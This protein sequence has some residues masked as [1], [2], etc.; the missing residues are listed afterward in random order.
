MSSTHR[1]QEWLPNSAI[2]DGKLLSWLSSIVAEWYE[3]WA[4]ENSNKTVSVSVKDVKDFATSKSELVGG[5]PRLNLSTKGYDRLAEEMIRQPLNNVSIN[6]TDKTLLK[7]LVDKSIDDLSSLLSIADVENENNNASDYS[8]SKFEV[9]M[10]DTVVLDIVLPMDFCVR[11][12]KSLASPANIERPVFE[13][14]QTAVATTQVDLDAKVGALEFDI[15][16]LK[17]LKIGD[18]LEFDR[19]LAEGFPLRA[20]GSLCENIQARFIL[21]QL[22]KGAKKQA[23]IILEKI[24]E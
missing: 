23:G 2:H 16:K 17:Q 12:R 21:T 8:K 7:G 19:T 1:Y 9:L 3:S 14:I 10:D 13:D 5:Q 11:H 4:G 15:G 20:N 24:D 6:K 18:V 22:K